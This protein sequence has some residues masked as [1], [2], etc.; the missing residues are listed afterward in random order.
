MLKQLPLA[1]FTVN[2]GAFLVMYESTVVVQDNSVPHKNT[3]VSMQTH[4]FQVVSI[5]VHL[6]LQCSPIL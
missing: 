4:Y 1:N 3:E 6:A 5:A 2:I